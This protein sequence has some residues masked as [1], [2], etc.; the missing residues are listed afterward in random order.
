MKLELNNSKAREQIENIEENHKAWF[1]FISSTREK[2]SQITYVIIH[3]KK[4]NAKWMGVMNYDK[5]IVKF[6]S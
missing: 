1:K 6:L 2:R 5:E 3:R 4:L